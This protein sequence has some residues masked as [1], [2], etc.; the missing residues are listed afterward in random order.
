MH[1]CFNLSFNLSD[2]FVLKL[3]R[4]L[5]V[6]T[7]RTDQV[8]PRVLAVCGEIH[9]RQD[10]IAIE[11]ILIPSQQL[12]RVKSLFLKFLSL[13]KES[14]IF[15]KSNGVTIHIYR[16]IFRCYNA[17]SLCKAFFIDCDAT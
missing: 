9:V 5:Y 16:V 6:Q 11:S 4:L 15:K 7:N 3:E 1:F 17:R 12:T 13:A 2:L 10:C 8:C 14:Y